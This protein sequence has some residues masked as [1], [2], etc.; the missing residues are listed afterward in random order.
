MHI[1]T[2]GLRALQGLGVLDAI[3]ARTGLDTVDRHLTVFISG[4][5][6][7]QLIYD[8]SIM[9]HIVEI[10]SNSSSMLNIA[11]GE[12]WGWESIGTHTSQN[13]FCE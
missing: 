9:S 12:V 5:G 13:L 6:D 7:H 8:A 2:N 3:V 10:S 4:T 11:Q 1:G